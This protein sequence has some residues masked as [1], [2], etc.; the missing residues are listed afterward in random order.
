MST[1]IV[2]DL[3]RRSFATR[4]AA[5]G[6]VNPLDDGSP[7]PF[8]GL[9]GVFLVSLTNLSSLPPDAHEFSFI[10]SGGTGLFR[11]DPSRNFHYKLNS[12]FDNEFVAVKVIPSVNRVI[13]ESNDDIVYQFDFP[14]P[15]A[16]GQD[17]FPSVSR[18]DLAPPALSGDVVVRV[19]DY[20]PGII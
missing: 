1:I 3:A 4:F 17:I 13:V 10:M 6:G 11:T 9:R 15:Q 20:T 14:P 16:I 8:R 19:Q 18:L 5:V 2:P 12:A 7:R